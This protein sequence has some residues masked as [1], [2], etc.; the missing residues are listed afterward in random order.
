MD[1]PGPHALPLPFFDAGWTS[2][3][4]SAAHALW[5]WH[6]HLRDGPI[7]GSTDAERQ[8]LM[9]AEH[10]RVLAGERTTVLSEDVTEAAFEAA[11]E[12]N[13]TRD[14]LAQQLLGAARWHG[15][16]RVGDWMELR[17]FLDGWA[18]PHARLLAQ[19]GGVRL[20]SQFRQVDELARGFFLIGALVRLPE[21]VRE[22]TLWVP[23]AALEKDDV[24]V[25]QLRTGAMNKALETLMWRQVIRA[26][27]ALAQGQ[28]LVYDLNRR[29][30]SAFKRYWLGG[31]EVLQEIERRGYDVWSAPVSLTWR[32]RLQV[33]Y[34]ARFGRTTFR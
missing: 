16:F 22:D 26:R 18:I 31:V 17:S 28:P 30:R 11:A 19:L 7:P 1:E 20:Q 9:Q 5:R 23:R 6:L 27:D 2:A 10:D 32:H 34:Q 33:E 12:H 25:E 3:Q 21:L 24:R 29:Q 8:D 14:Y 15:M 13:L 4:R